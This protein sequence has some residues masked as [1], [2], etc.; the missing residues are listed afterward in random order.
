MTQ[1]YVV[2]VCLHC[3]QYVASLTSNTGSNSRSCNSEDISLEDIPL[4]D[5]QLLK[6]IDST[7]KLLYQFAEKIPANPES[8]EFQHILHII[9][10]TNSSNAWKT[11]YRP[12]DERCV[13]CKTALCPLQHLPG[14]NTKAFLLTK[15]RF[16]PVKALIRRCP[17]PDCLARHPYRTWREGQ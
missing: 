15:A 6:T 5:I 3:I 16:L 9:S 4:K 17:N 10:A 14:S 1:S 2:L 7:T 8:I 13:L 11:E 12:E